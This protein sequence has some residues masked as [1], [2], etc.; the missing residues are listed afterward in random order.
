MQ[1]ETEAISI[2]GKRCARLWGFS[3]GDAIRRKLKEISLHVSLSQS[4]AICSLQ[5]GAVDLARQKGVSENY[6][7]CLTRASHLF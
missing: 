1:K 4:R 2:P 5:C 7:Q 6:C 3:L